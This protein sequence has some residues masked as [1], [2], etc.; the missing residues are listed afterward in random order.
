VTLNWERPPFYT[1]AVNWLRGLRKTA[2]NR[3][4]W[5]L[6]ACHGVI[7][8]G[9]NTGQERRKYARHG[10]S[11]VWIEPIPD[12]F[13]QLQ[14]NLV[15][16]PKQVAIQALIADSDGASKTL[17]IASNGGAS[18]SFLTPLLHKD[19]WPGV[20]FDSQ[21]VLSTLT[22]PTALARLS[23]DTT[24]FDALVMDV[25]GAELMVLK[26]AGK[27]LNQFKFILTEAADFEAYGGCATVDQL[28]SHLVEHGFRCT[29]KTPFAHR[30]E[31]GA[32]YNMLFQRG[33]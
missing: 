19:V 11:V 28:E 26:G 9:A 22:L 15:G 3:D 8:V 29:Q 1:R 23:A 33:I 14:F 27:Q 12:V 4:E 7:H 13:S 24:G 17:N 25:Q 32:Y 20:A 5:F 21:I 16:F 30:A 31:G 2:A 18:S 10:L 6:S